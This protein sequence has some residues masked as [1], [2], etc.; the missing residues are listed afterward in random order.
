LS[1]DLS[2]TFNQLVIHDDCAFFPLL[3]DDSAQ[4]MIESSKKQRKSISLDMK[5]QV[6]LCLEAGDWQVDMNA[7]LDLA[8]STIRTII[9]NVDVIKFSA[10]TTWNFSTAKVTRSRTHLFE[11]VESRLSVRVTDQTRRC[12]P[13]S[14]MLIMKKA[15]SIFCHIQEKIRDDSEKFIDSRGWF[16]RFER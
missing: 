12:M 13:L 2:E 4:E 9:K 15:K 6:L 5:L 3:R 11:Q 8:T 1:L 10:P 16:G 14:Q 7:S